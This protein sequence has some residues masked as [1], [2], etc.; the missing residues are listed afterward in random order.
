MA[1]TTPELILMLKSE[2]SDER[3]VASRRIWTDWEK[4]ENKDLFHQEED[5]FISLLQNE[6]NERNI[7]HIMIILGLINSV[8]AI[9]II[10]NL[11]KTS[12]IE[13]IRGFAADSLSRYKQHVLDIDTL[14]LLWSLSSTDP[15][16]VVRVNSIRACSNQFKNSG[17]KEISIRL[18][19]LL[20][21]QT[22]SAI[23]TTILQQLGEIGS[24]VVVPDLI[25]IMITR[26]TEIDKKMAGIAL[27]MIAKSNG[28]QNRQDLIKMFA[29][30]DI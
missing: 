16:L 13:N 28:Y 19:E 29:S 7:W 8:K 23:K 9:P 12:T 11:L 21:E 26:R 6:E 5:Y 25:H 18:F 10:V 4:L 30:K 22:H 15:S 14:E 17:N 27:D 24:T 1:F 20:E 3:G 2:N